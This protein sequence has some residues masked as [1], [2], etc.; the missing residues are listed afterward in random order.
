MFP[1]LLTWCWQKSQIF[2]WN[3]LKLKTPQLELEIRDEK[4]PTHACDAFEMLLM[5][6]TTY[7]FL[8]ESALFK[9][10]NIDAFD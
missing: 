10:A 8:K 1:Y 6:P 2:Y 3:A 4:H 9:P 7:F 5:N